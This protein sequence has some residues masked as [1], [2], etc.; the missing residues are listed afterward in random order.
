MYVSEK[1][2]GED[3]ECE[4]RD[5]GW[6]L[7]LVKTGTVSKVRNRYAMERLATMATALVLSHGDY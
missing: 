3:L 7:W 1:K 4:T 5:G 6:Q 2:D